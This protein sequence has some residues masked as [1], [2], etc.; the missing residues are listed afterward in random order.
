MPGGGNKFVVRRDETTGLYVVL[1][2][3][4]T[5][6][7]AGVDQRNVLE[8]VVSPDLASWRRVATIL[9]DDTGLTW[10][11]SL[12]YTGFHYVDFQF[13]SGDESGDLIAV[14]RT[15]YRGAVCCAMS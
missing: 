6:A 7:A 2:N 13:G 15:A 11:D 1:A 9:A 5:T 12:R 4:Q 14:I 10:P 3:P 8:L